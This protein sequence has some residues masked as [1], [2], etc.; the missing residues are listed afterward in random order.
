MRILGWSASTLGVIGV[1]AGN[2]LAS[3]VWVVALNVRGRAHN[4]LAIPE[5][6]LERA[7]ELTDTV[8]GRIGDVSGLVADI[9]AKAVR[10]A[11]APDIDP[12]AATDLATAISDFVTGP[13][14]DMRTGYAMVRERVTTVAD[15][16][17]GLGRS[18]PFLTLPDVAV[19]RLQAIDARLVEFDTAIT[20]LA[21]AG[22]QG[23]S[24]PGV[25]ADISERAGNVLETLASVGERVTEVGARLQESRD[26]VAEA[27]RRVA[28]RLTAGAAAASIV[29]L[30]FSGLNVLLFQQGRRWSRR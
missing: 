6:G 28:R 12:A 19:D 29:S 14:A 24:E 21:S 10:L 5:G 11:E 15:A 9:K 20:H 7:I 8:A 2:G 4:L 3:V 25:A 22:V 26:R 27:D 16:I 1:M 13:Y 17:E 30:Y 18:V 23:I